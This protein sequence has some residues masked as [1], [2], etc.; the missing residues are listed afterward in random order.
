MDEWQ[1]GT[2]EPLESSIAMGWT[3]DWAQAALQSRDAFASALRSVGLPDDEIERSVAPRDDTAAQLHA[4]ELEI[5]RY[6][7]PGVMFAEDPVPP[8]LYAQRKSIRQRLIDLFTGREIRVLET[9]ETELHVPLFLLAGADVEGCTARFDQE[10]MRTRPLTW[11]LTV[12]GSGFGGSRDLKASAAASFAA[13]AG[14]LK[15]VFQPLKLT[16]QRV[17]VLQNGRE[18]GSGVQANSEDVRTDASPGLLLLSPSGRPPT[19]SSVR[20]FPLA[21]DTSGALA[22]YRWTYERTTKKNL[23][24]GVNAFNTNMSVTVGNELTTQ[25]SLQYE[26]RGGH[27]YALVRVAE[28]DGLMWAPTEPRPA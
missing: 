11:S 12:F 22:T 4:I 10:S 17:V 19:G 5:E 21:G 9:A 24:I 13:G 28:G 3:R 18:I 26:L 6:L 7:P 15:V 8:E 14:E 27:D 25:V 16:L 2:T 1:T 23:S 20:R